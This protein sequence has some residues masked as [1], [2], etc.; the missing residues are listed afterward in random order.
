MT[1]KVT[2]AGKGPKFENLKLKN[3]KLKLCEKKFS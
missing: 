2:F 1:S 3:S